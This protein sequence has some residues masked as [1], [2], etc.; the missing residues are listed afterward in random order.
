[1]TWLEL[2]RDLGVFGIAGYIFKVVISKSV[3]LQVEY[4]KSQLEK[5]IF[6]YSR[7]HERRIEIISLVYANLVDLHS[8]MQELTAKIK[9]VRQDFKAEDDIRFQK[10]IS[11]YQKFRESYDRNKLYIDPD[12]CLNLDKLKTKYYN[13]LGDYTFIQNPEFADMASELQKGI[14]GDIKKTI[15]NILNDLEVAFSNCIS[16]E[17]P[18]KGMKK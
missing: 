5:S 15:P 17:E 11:N 9:W 7:Y 4:Y 12:I 1:M 3:T 18:Q 16:Y 10:A 8:S 2:L 6:K 14:Q 13:M